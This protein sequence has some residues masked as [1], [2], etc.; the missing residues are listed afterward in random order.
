[1][2]AMRYFQAESKMLGL[3]KEDIGDVTLRLNQSDIQNKE[4]IN[5]ETAFD[6]KKFKGLRVWYRK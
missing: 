3:A 6:G 4:I 5:I 2:I 1:M